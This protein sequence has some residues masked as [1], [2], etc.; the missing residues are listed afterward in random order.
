MARIVLGFIDVSLGANVMNVTITGVPRE[1]KLPQK[2][3]HCG[4]CKASQWTR[5]GRMP[6]DHD[7]PDGRVCHPHPDYFEWTCKAVG[8]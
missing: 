4:L 3:A 5:D 2:R 6:V 7:R 1:W 8:A